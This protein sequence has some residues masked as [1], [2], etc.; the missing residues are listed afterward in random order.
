MN[1]HVDITEVGL[2]EAIQEQLNLVSPK[3]MLRGNKIA[4]R[5]GQQALKKYHRG[6]G[7]AMWITPGPTHGPGREQTGWYKQVAAAWATGAV[8]ADGAQLLNGASFFAHKV[9]GGVIRAK[10]VKFLTIPL[11][12]EAHGKTARQYAQENGTKLFTIPG[13]PILFRQGG[14]RV[15]DSSRSQSVLSNTIGRSKGGRKIGIAAKSKL[16]AVYA[17]KKSVTQKPTPGA[18][19]DPAVYMEPYEVAL[20]TSLLEPSK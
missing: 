17:L 13:V 3:A 11:I 5:A 14:N 4:A 7:R 19:P 20:I 16:T 9:T 6:K 12:P 18:L 2:D 8:S 10:R 1:T 15:G